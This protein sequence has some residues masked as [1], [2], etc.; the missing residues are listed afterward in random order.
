MC[1][2]AMIHQWNGHERDS[3]VWNMHGIY[4][5]AIKG[6]IHQQLTYKN[7]L[8]SVHSCESNT[9]TYIYIYIYILE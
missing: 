1:G 4:I 2:I 7:M 8:K 9:H 6:I 5:C 3:H